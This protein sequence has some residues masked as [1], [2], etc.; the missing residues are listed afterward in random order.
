VLPTLIATLL[1]GAPDHPVVDFISAPMHGWLVAYRRV[2]CAAAGW[3][4]EH[5]IWALAIY[6]SRSPTRH[7]RQHL[8]CC[9]CARR[10]LCGLPCVARLLSRAGLASMGD[11]LCGQHQLCNDGVGVIGTQV[12]MVEGSVQTVGPEGANEIHAVISSI[13]SSTAIVARVYVGSTSTYPRWT[14]TG[15]TTHPISG[16]RRIP[17]TRQRH[18]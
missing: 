14:A 1:V 16:L 10:L 15:P 3:I 7:R 9:A 17:T 5:L 11:P 4:I 8:S 2:L 6:A 13:L 18:A 12:E